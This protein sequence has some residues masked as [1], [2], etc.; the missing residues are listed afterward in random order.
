MSD[1]QYDVSIHGGRGFYT[2]FTHTS[3]AVT[4][5]EAHVAREHWNGN[6][7][8]FHVDDGRLSEVIAEDMLQ[9]GLT[10]EY[11]GRALEL[12]R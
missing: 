3:E 6:A 8:M 4:W 1:E 2:F 11:N 9:S 12:A 10:I 7:Q 5:I